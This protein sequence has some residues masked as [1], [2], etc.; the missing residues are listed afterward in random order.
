LYSDKVVRVFE[1]K[2]WKGALLAFSIALIFIA[3]IVYLDYY[4]GI[5]IFT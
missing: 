5:G 2:T 4:L 1:I 3:L